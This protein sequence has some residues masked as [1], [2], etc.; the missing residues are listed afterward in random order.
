[1]ETME[2]EDF[3]NL[4]LQEI[5]E[6]EKSNFSSRRTSLSQDDRPSKKLKSERPKQ[7]FV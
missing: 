2:A 1:M 6:S 5:Q 4:D 7:S 3:G